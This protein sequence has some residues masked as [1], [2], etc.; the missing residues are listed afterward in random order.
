MIPASGMSIP[1]EANTSFQISHPPAMCS[2]HPGLCLHVCI[3]GAHTHP[4]K[5]VTF[6]C[7]SRCKLHEARGPVCSFYPSVPVIRVGHE[8]TGSKMREETKK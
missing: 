1:Q 3:S 8:L 2:Q 4:W 7:P 5:C 6:V